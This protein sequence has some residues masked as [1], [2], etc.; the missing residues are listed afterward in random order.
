MSQYLKGNYKLGRPAASSEAKKGKGKELEPK[1]EAGA[2]FERK[3]LERLGGS[4]AFVARGKALVWKGR[5][6]GGPERR[7]GRVT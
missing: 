2:D 3:A 5:T 7:L 4:I 6:E 1:A